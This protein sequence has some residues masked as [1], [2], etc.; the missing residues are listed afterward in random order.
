[1]KLSTLIP[2]RIRNRANL[3]A[4]GYLR[5][6]HPSLYKLIKFGRTNINTPQYWD[7]VWNSDELHRA[8][9]ELFQA[10]LDRIPQHARVIDVGCGNGRLAKLVRQE[11]GAQVTCLDFSALVLGRLAADGFD[12]I[13]SALPA[14]PAPDASFDVAVSTEVFEHL[15]DPRKTLRQMARVVR[16]GGMVIFSVP[17]DALLPHEELEHQSSF[18]RAKVA[19][20]TQGLFAEVEIVTGRLL[21]GSNHEYLLTC[22]LVG[23]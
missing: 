17:N 23:T 1:M 8:Y 14:I 10:I 12:T 4:E 6:R 13:V 2:W 3:F 5:P 7:G 15:D 11:R 18:D 20:M 22:A 16:P 19:A 21:D 9:H